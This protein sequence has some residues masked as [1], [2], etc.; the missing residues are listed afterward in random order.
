M[1]KV[2]GMIHYK[3][4]VRITMVCGRKALLD[5]RRRIHQD[6]RISSMLSAKE[7]QLAQAV[8]RMK[9][10]KGKTEWKLG[11][12]R[13]DYFQLKNPAYAAKGRPSGPLPGGA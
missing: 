2:T 7:D 13:K 9:E 6:M 8:E 12:L 1:I 4:G 11:Q 5:Y 10:E 3:G